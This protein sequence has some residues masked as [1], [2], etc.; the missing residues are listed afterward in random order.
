[1]VVESL[2]EESQAP[3]G[4]PGQPKDQ[5]AQPPEHVEAGG[6]QTWT[7]DDGIAVT[8]DEDQLLLESTAPDGS[9]ASDASSV[10][11]TWLH[12]KLICLHVRRPRMV[13]PPSRS[14]LL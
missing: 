10:T 13:I 9:P 12:Y 1:M 7:S 6:T 11:D 8:A 2:A 3:S 4:P 5:E 14:H